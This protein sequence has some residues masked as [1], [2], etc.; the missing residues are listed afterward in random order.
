[1]TDEELKV[2]VEQTIHKTFKETLKYLNDRKMLKEPEDVVYGDAVELITNYYK[3]GKT[4]QDITYAIQGLRFDPY[5]KIIPM[6]F[7]E[8]Q[9]IEC[10]AEAL[11]VDV[12][13]VTRNKKRLCIAIYHE[14]V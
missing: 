9:K 10:I 12:R 4:N 1:M 5:F 11:K 8:G 13:T 7:E 14:V 3:N 2:M 6:Y